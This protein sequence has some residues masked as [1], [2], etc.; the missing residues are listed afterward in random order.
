MK[1]LFKISSGEHGRGE[2]LVRWQPEGNLLATA[3]KNGELRRAPR[4][5]AQAMTKGYL[6]KD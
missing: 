1:P 3:G 2:V 5:T 6:Q 4:G